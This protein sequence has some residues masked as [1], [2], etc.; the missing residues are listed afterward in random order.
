MQVAMCSE[1]EC[2]VPCLG[3]IGY[4]DTASSHFKG[5]ES[6]ALARM[7]GV[8]CRDVCRVLSSWLQS[9]VWVHLA[10]FGI[11]RSTP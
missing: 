4:P 5:G 6:A 11:A 7:A 2:A 3:D 1:E 8:H 10:A 9:T